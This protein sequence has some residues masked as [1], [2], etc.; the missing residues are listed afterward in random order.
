MSTAETFD[1]LELKSQQTPKVGK[2]VVV[3]GG[4]VLEI[5]E[6]N[7]DEAVLKRRGRNKKITRSLAGLEVVFN[8][9]WKIGG[10][11]PVEEHIAIQQA[12]AR[13]AK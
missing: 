8:K 7:G 2:L 5:V 9:E 11:R 3:P 1:L 13:L 6:I 4:T 12:K 10:W